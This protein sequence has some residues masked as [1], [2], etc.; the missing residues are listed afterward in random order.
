MQKY[1]HKF[2]FSIWFACSGVTCFTYAIS[3]LICHYCDELIL[4]D[5]KCCFVNWISIFILVIIMYYY[6]PS[7][8]CRTGRHTNSA[9]RFERY[10]SCRYFCYDG[11]YHNQFG[12]NNS[13]RH[14]V[15]L[16]IKI[17][18]GNY[19]IAAYVGQWTGSVLIQAMA[20]Q[21]FS[22]KPWPQPVLTYCQLRI[23]TRNLSEVLI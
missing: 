21:L 22:A 6:I 4:C 17:I 3:F 9:V 2:L 14:Q 5:F 10:L 16:M 13:G 15:M 20:W 8:T 19:H 18:Y 1:C 23:S 7:M 12:V 11:W